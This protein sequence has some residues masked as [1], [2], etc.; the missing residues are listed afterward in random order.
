[1]TDSLGHTAATTCPIT[2]VNITP[3]PLS[4]TCAAVNTGQV[5]VAFNSGAM[6]VTG[7]TTPYV[8]A[9]VGTLPAGLTLDTTTGAVSGTPTAAGT[10]SVQVTDAHGLTGTACAITIT[11][12]TNPSCT[13]GIANAYNL[14]ALTGDIND[15][16]DITGRI[17]ANGQVTQATTIGTDLRTSDPYFNLASANGGPYAIVAGGGIP[18]SNSFNVN[19]GGNVYSSTPTS[20]TFNFVNEF[21]PGSLYMGSKLVTGG[22]TPLDFP[23]LQTTMTNLSAPLAGVTPNGAICTV[24]NFGKMVPGN[25]CPTNPVYFNPNSQHYNPSWIVLYG[26]NTTVNVFNISQPI[27]ETTNNLDIEVPT[28]STVVINVAGT[29]VTLHGDIYFQ[30]NTSTIPEASNIL[31]NFPAATSVTMNGQID[32]TVLAPQ[33]YLSGGSQMGGI[34]IAASI[35]PTGE[36]HYV[37]FTGNLPLPGCVQ[38]TAQ[39]ISFSLASPVAL[40]V[41]PITLSA[42]A[43]SG[44]PVAFSW[45][46]GPATVSGSTLTINGA[47]TVVVAADQAGNSI[48]AAAPQVTQT[49]IVNKATPT[50]TWATP[51]PI[52]EGTTLDTTHQL[53]ATASVP[54][55]FVYDPSAGTTPAVG[56]DTLSVTF[57]PTDTADYTT[58]TASV[59]LV[60]NSLSNPVPVISGLAPAHTPAGGPDFTLTVSGTGFLASSTVYFGGTQ[61]TTHFDSNTQSLTATVPAALIASSAQVNVTVVS[62]APGGGTSSAFVFQVDTAGTGPG[63]TPGFTTSAATVS[64]G[65]TATYPVTPPSSATNVSAVCVNVPAGATCSYSPTTGAVTITTSSGM[66]KGIYQI[67]VVFTETLPGAATGFVVLPFLLLPLLLV[68][69]KM[70]KKGIWLSLSLLVALVL[71][72]GAM[73]GC[74]GGSSFTTPPPDQ[75]HQVKISGTVSLTVK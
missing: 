34:F 61:L 62:P 14:I 46:S 65:S 42:S 38:P 43:T 15:A 40:G 9:V 23:T 21:Y 45:V 10:F 64:A 71:G 73:N 27:F 3:P 53:N 5:G 11:P 7:G 29:S 36:V 75:T 49:L 66:A 47:G 44:L 58:A 17:A 30:G 2:I 52:T 72:V 18:T 60:V 6:T 33:A 20:A 51:A 24:D 28:G 8:F 50:I 35:G 57:T 54:G 39:T 22:S 37:P 4:V 41:A 68:R 13:L 19:A 74:G 1:V 70:A 56:N 32:A 12:S 25:G 55:T 26:A 67:T 63:A 48:Y 59:V 31:F 69:R 16:A